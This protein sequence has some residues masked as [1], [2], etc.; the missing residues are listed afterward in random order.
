MYN[1]QLH[2]TNRDTTKE[3]LNYSTVHCSTERNEEEY[4]NNYQN[5]Y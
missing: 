2:K 5:Y 3:V 1:R 4:D